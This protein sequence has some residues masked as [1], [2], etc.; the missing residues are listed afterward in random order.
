LKP[1]RL[2]EGDI[3]GYGV[4]ISIRHLR[5]ETKFSTPVESSYWTLG[6]NDLFR[7][8]RSTSFTITPGLQVVGPG[9]KAGLF[10]GIIGVGYARNHVRECFWET[11]I[12]IAKKEGEDVSGISIETK[13]TPIVFTILPI[14]IERL[15][16]KDIAIGIDFSGLLCYPGK[17]DWKFTDPE[18][19][20][21][22]ES[23]WLT[24][25]QIGL[26]LSLCLH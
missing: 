17:T 18:L 2:S 22:S 14:K 10:I 19:G 5:Q 26:T 4:E 16:Y 12:E 15:L 20:F 8:F 3:G 25:I 9:S 1:L 6:K 21:P 11:I 7:E 23:F 13:V 24:N